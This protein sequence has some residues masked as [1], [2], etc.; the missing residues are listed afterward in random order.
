MYLMK[1]IIVWTAVANFEKTKRIK[2]T[3][4]RLRI[5]ESMSPLESI[6]IRFIG[7]TKS[8]RFTGLNWS[9]WIYCSHWSIRVTWF[10]GDTGLI[11][12]IKSIGVIESIGMNGSFGFPESIVFTGAIEIIRALGLLESL[13]PLK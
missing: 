5:S 10:I 9:H 2:T 8:I 1:I 11:R 13:R 12:V 3:G 7:A 6:C 4:L